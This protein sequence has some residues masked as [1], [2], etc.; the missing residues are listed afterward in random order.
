MTKQEHEQQA[1]PGQEV[2]W[3]VT[4]VVINPEPPEGPAY[5]EISVCDICGS[6]NG[7]RRP[8]E[9]PGS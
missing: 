8:G 6:E 4:Y 5:Y 7:L 1:H 2:T 3:T 9:P